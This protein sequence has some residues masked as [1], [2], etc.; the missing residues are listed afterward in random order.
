MASNE[1]DISTLSLDQLN[2]LK[3]QHEQEL[4]QLRAKI[5]AE[6]TKVIAAFVDTSES[7][8]GKV[9]LKRL[10]EAADADNSGTLDKA[11]IRAAANSV[12]AALTPTM[13]GRVADRVRRNIENV[14]RTKG[15]NFYAEGAPVRELRA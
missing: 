7:A 8:F 14:I 15:G 11:E 4:N 5:I 10:F 2:Q 6:H 13:L 3:S 1:M 12:F 9:A